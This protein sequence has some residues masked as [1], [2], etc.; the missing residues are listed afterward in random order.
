MD[1]TGVTLQVLPDYQLKLRFANGSEA[2]INMSHR[3]RAIRF[4]RLSSPEL[5]GVGQ[6]GGRRSRV[7]K[8]K[9]LRTGRPST[10]CWTRCR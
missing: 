6:T 9:L 4:G 1:M 7:G 2:L 5:F 10:S 8:R 3:L